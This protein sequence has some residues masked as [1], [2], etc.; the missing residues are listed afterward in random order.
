MDQHGDESL[1]AL[2]GDALDFAQKMQEDLNS[3]HFLLSFF[4]TPNEV[5]VLFEDIGVTTQKIT[6]GYKSV[7]KQLLRDGGVMKDPEGIIKDIE[8]KALS[9]IHGEHDKPGPLH[10]L[11]AITHE[12][13]CMANR[14]LEHVEV[15]NKVRL[16]GLSMLNTPAKR[17]KA[18]LSELMRE[19]T[20]VQ[21]TLGGPAQK[22]TVAL[23]EQ[24]DV[25][26][27]SEVPAASE[28]TTVPLKVDIPQQRSDV[29]KE[30]VRDIKELKL[31][32]IFGQFG[33]NLTELAFMER[34]EPICGR[35]Q[36]IE[37]ILD[38]LGR[39]KNNNPLIVGPAGS[40]KTALVE[41]IA[42]RQRQGLLP[43]RIIWELSL[44]AFLSGTEY[45]G[46]L[47][48]RINELVIEVE[49]LKDII[50]VF[51]DEIHLINSESSEIFAN[52]LK[53]ALSRGLFPLIGATTPDEFKKFI[54]KD[55]A[56]ERRFTLVAIAEPEGEELYEIVRHAAEHLSKYHH[57]EMSG[58]ELVRAAIRLSSRYISGRS[59]PDKVLS[60]LDT[61]GSL[62]AR[63]GKQ[64][65]SEQDIMELVSVK[66][67][68]PLDNLLIDAGGIMRRL[69]E[70]MD[71]AIKG[72][73]EAKRQ[74]VQLLARR[75]SRKN[76]PRP[77]ASLIFAGPTGVGKTE[78]AKRL[79][80]FFFGSEKKMVVFDMSEF[81]EQHAVSRLIGSPPGYTGFDEG[82]R[83]TE[84][85]RR[86][87]YQLLLL[88]EI[89]KAHPKVLAILLQ[90]L[91]EGRLTDSRGFTVNMSECIVVMTT[92]LGA[93][94]FSSSRLGFGGRSD[95]R[96]SGAVMGRIE[97]HI[98][99]ELAGRV[100][101][102]VVFSPFSEADY[103]D[104]S[105]H[106][107]EKMRLS[108]AESYGL[109]VSFDEELLAGWLAGQLTQKDKQ[110]GA[111]PL[112]RLI[113]KNI[114]SPLLNKLYTTGGA[115]RAEIKRPDSGI[116]LA[117]ELF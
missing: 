60:L 43:G 84:A 4:T 38:I 7:R 80:E 27:R 94:E 31:P 64:A 50:I 66:T 112:Q 45:R 91:E 19:S 63:G 28:T 90:I 22:T 58:E 82:G 85:F 59:Q 54:A 35:T 30:L 41:G 92:N 77:I 99:P 101:E 36:E 42:D 5:A 62:L 56:M 14:I 89:E 17:I 20:H 106:F 68:I 76:G 12:R 98:S 39:K 81:Q 104:L 1:V 110:Q 46:S 23:R 71:T 117:I 93:E 26:E 113:E 15:L 109:S 67:G 86:E 72:Q 37:Q 16:E 96:R 9:F 87:P 107:L 24:P 65:A 2:Y 114:E 75:F 79:A 34:I 108:L 102:V 18:R 25:A 21:P 97:Q 40:G 3:F 74:I 11:C 57:V 61:L 44:S 48:K 32:E 69:P 51:I 105:I 88:D 116:D 115:V 52:M 13:R 8:K 103:R 29:A 49:R 73:H 95:D 55:P 78:M 33:R 47:E 53:P 111:R 6:D 83:L 70:R 100:D 10:I